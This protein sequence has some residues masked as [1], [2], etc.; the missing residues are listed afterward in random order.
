MC[1]RNKLAQLKQPMRFC[2]RYVSLAQ[3]QGDDG[4]LGNA[5]TTGAAGDLAGALGD[6]DAYTGKPPTITGVSVLLQLR[7]SADQAF[8]RGVSAPKR[9]RPGQTVRL[10]LTLQRVRGTA[11][12]RGYSVRIPG[13]LHAG[14]VKLR[15]LG[16]DADGGDSSLAT[17]IVIGDGS[18]DT[19]GDSGPTSLSALA[20]EVAGIAAYDG[21]TLRMGAERAR[22]FRDNDF[23][24][25]GRAETTVHV[26]R[27]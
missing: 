19:S 12:T 8:I 5:V 2:N 4:S 20:G 25:S 13:G 15:L 7:R 3:E 26:V 16:R 27:R 14:T 23:R 1:V 9:V 11:F 10:R 21:V 22:A 17:T 18:E 24:I 6:I